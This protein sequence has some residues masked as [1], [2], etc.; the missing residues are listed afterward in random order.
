MFAPKS[1]R[2]T[3]K[4]P[5]Q[6][7]SALMLLGLSVPSFATAAGDDSWTFAAAPMGQYEGGLRV[8]DRSGISYACAGFYSAFS[9]TVAGDRLG[10]AAIHIDGRHFKDIILTASYDQKDSVYELDVKAKSSAAAKQNLNS[11]I[12]AVAA[13]SSMEIRSRDGAEVFES[14]TLNGSS[15]AKVCK[16]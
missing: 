7:F 1:T 11:L 15:K 13:G 3:Y 12:D 4:M 9:I 8:S 5:T 2:K 10:H 16:M 14:Y 6:L